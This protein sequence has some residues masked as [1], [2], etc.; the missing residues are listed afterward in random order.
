[1][2]VLTIL[3]SCFIGQ[4]T[5]YLLGWYAFVGVGVGFLAAGVWQLWPRGPVLG[6]RIPVLGRDEAV[7]RRI[8][9]DEVTALRRRRRM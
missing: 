6:I 2:N 1:M 4:V 5:A 7:P 8:T 3:L 9:T